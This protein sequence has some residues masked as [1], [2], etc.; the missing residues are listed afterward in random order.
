ML[1]YGRCMPRTGSFAARPA[2]VVCCA[3]AACGSD[4]G[5][6]PQVAAPAYPTGPYGTNV[7]EVIQNLKF[8]TP[9]GQP[10]ELES[11]YRGPMRA[12]VLYGT[13]TWCFTCRD[14]TEWL[15]AKTAAATVGAV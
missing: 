5:P 13:A 9:E 14:E 4:A 2:M 10:F 12:V 11:L 6:E 3:V 8:V 7:G 1:I 15:N